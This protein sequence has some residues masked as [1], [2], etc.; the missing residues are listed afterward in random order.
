L[1]VIFYGIAS[2][3]LL[4]LNDG[5]SSI[6]VAGAGFDVAAS[7]MIEAW[8]MFAFGGFTSVNRVEIA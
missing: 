3:L 6:V 4:V 1:S 8:V 7:T 2:N 5:V